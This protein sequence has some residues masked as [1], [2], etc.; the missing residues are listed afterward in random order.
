[1]YSVKRKLELKNKDSV[2]KRIDYLRDERN[3]IWTSLMVTLGGTLA[4]MFNL[5]SKLKIIF[6]I[7][8]VLFSIIFFYAYFKKDEKFELLIKKIEEE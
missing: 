5:N 2:K 6:F 8:G 3:H 1:M 4:L 7:F